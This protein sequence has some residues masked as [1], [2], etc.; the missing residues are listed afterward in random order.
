[1]NNLTATCYIKFNDSHFTYLQPIANIEDKDIDIV[2]LYHIVIEVVD[3]YTTP[4][5]LEGIYQ[6]IIPLYSLVMS[7]HNSLITLVGTDKVRLSEFKIKT[8]QYSHLPI[9][10]ANY[11]SF[12]SPIQ[13]L[14]TESGYNQYL[15]RRHLTNDAKFQ[16]IKDNF[17]PRLSIDELLTM[18]VTEK[19][20]TIGGIYFSSIMFQVVV[21]K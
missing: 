13:F 12:Y 4:E 21:Q 7:K 14:N 11:N 5:I 2:L 10:H 8:K 9:L 6:N 1:M 15:L 19:M 16:L 20:F 17:Y 18:K 3:V